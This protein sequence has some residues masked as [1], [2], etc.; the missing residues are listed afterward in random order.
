[1]APYNK[2]V[3]MLAGPARPANGPRMVRGGKLDINS[4]FQINHP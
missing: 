3:E 1:M 4:P 2:G